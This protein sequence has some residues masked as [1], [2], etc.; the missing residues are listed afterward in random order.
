MKK[1]K[2]KNQQ[3]IPEKRQITPERFSSRL[4]VINVDNTW[5]KQKQCFPNPPINKEAGHKTYQKA[6]HALCI[7]TQT[8]NWENLEPGTLE[9]KSWCLEEDFL[10]N[11][12]SWNEAAVGLGWR[13]DPGS[14]R[15]EDLGE[16]KVAWK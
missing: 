10:N 4:L 6:D 14:E 9:K 12:Q 13:K 1:I 15:R 2:I 8:L 11:K 7:W 3:N 5:S 16:Q